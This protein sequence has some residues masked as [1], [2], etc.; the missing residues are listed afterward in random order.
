MS[1]PFKY[2]Q[3]GVLMLCAFLL[4][5]TTSAQEINLPLSTYSVFLTSDSTVEGPGFYLIQTSLHAALQHQGIQVIRE[6]DRDHLI[7]QSD[8]KRAVLQDYFT[9]AWPVNDLWK[10]SPSLLR[11]WEQKKRGRHKYV[12]KVG[13]LERFQS[14]LLQE[15]ISLT[16]IR[17]IDLSTQSLL[18]YL[19]QKTIEQTILPSH[20]VQ[21]VDLHASPP[22]EE[23][24]IQ[25]LDLSLN[26]ISTVH[27]LYP[28][29]D[30]S[31]LTVSIKENSFDPQDI[32]L[33][34]REAPS[35]LKSNLVTTHATTMAT[36]I[37]GAGNSFHNGKGVATN[38][39]LSASSFSNLMPDEDAY[40]STNQIA[41]QNHSYGLPVENYYGLEAMAYDQQVQRHPHLL[42]VFSAGNNGEGTSEEGR[43]KDISGY[44]NLT[45]NMK[46]AK[47]ILTVGSLDSLS[48]VPAA[49]SRGPAFDGRVKPELVAFGE[50]GS[51][52]AAALTS[53]SVV[54]LQQAFQERYGQL[55]PASLIRALLLNTADDI[56]APGPD[57]V[58]GYGKLDILG[59]IEALREEQFFLDTIKSQSAPVKTFSLQIP[60][61]AIDLKITLAWSDPPATLNS[62]M[63]L[64]NDL[65]L[66][67]EGEQSGNLFLPWV[68]N[69]TPEIDSL[70]SPAKRGQDRLNNQEQVTIS[71][72]AD[73]SLIV[74]ITTNQLPVE[75]QS[76]SIAYEYKLPEQFRWLF[77]RETDHFPAGEKKR[78][79]WETTFQQ[80][81]QL[82][83][84]L[85]DSNEW[86]SISDN[87]AL[88]EFPPLW[89][90]PDTLAQVQLK[91]TIGE[92]EFLSDTITIS[93]TSVLSLELNCEES[94]I[95]SWNKVPGA[96]GYQLYAMQVRSL[97]PVLEITDTFVILEKLDYPYT[98]YAVAAVL[99]NGSIATK[100]RSINLNF[101]SA[102]CYISNFLA[103]LVGDRVEMQLS[104]G[105]LY[106]L[107]EIQFQKYD[108]GQFRTLTSFTSPSE[109]FYRTEDLNLREGANIYRAV[110]FLQNGTSIISDEISLLYTSKDF[111]VFP[112]PTHHLE[113]I[114]LIAKD[115]DGVQ[116]LL[117]DNL[118]RLVVQ[119][120]V[121]SPFEQVLTDQFTPG[122]YH[123]MILQGDN[124]R[125]EGKIVVH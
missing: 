1:M 115:T 118:G 14:F 48:R 37:G 32:D 18:L 76:F 47:N 29:L 16:L 33:R 51:S 27:R 86:I 11:Q 52:G 7:I 55:A 89:S 3:L 74:K 98:E 19:D 13:D 69:A 104:L 25:G 15:N 121:L 6:L 88:D 91:M 106:E 114:S 105:S 62:N 59:A 53:G 116:I 97:E 49:S 17:K 60:S 24:G 94:S 101:Q 5:I 31:S 67:V 102:G 21:F 81:G 44:A 103:D 71:S 8:L 119:Q 4:T 75:Q 56:G 39:Q 100:S 82:Y 46:M 26:N 110:V 36:L 30:G 77:P 65:D 64:V 40:F 84:K 2:C 43:Y 68:L 122:V 109:L 99:P 34:N 123:Y 41:T 23:R 108:L 72:P 73:S 92:R 10:L 66:E 112:N 83:Y 113:G 70:T 42:H 50:D 58:S 120:D 22:L 57:Y 85:L 78:L 95:L 63:A 96:I 124:R 93:S 45:G 9:R 61:Q 90:I 28:Q 80:P 38:V 79:L 12:I 107:K 20:L 87:V 111:L 35:D 117:F 54:L 125:A